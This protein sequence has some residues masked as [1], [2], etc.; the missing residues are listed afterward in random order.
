[1]S[2]GATKKRGYASGLGSNANAWSC[3]VIF[4][5]AAEISSLLSQKLESMLK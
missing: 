2:Y 4:V 1:M 3:V 5:D